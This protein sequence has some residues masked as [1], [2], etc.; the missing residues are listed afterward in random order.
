MKNQLM[1]I[2][3]VKHHTIKKQY[4]NF[5]FTFE[6]TKNTTIGDF[7]YFKLKYIVFVPVN[8]PGA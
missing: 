2:R 5:V 8:K 1:N 6:N 3:L 4:E 7:Y